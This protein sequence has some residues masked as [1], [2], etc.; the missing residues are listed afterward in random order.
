MCMPAE[1]VDAWMGTVHGTSRAR[2]T[3]PSSRADDID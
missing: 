3:G 2:C 1:C